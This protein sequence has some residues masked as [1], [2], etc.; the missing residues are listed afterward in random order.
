MRSQYFRFEPRW[1]DTARQIAA[2]KVRPDA[3]PGRKAWE[4]GPN[5]SGLSPDG[6]TPLGKL[7]HRRCDPMLAQAGGLGM[8]SQYFRFEPR[9]GDTARQ[10]AAPKVRLDA[11]PGRKAW[12]C[13][14]NISG[15]NPDGATPL[16]KLQHRRCDSMLAQAGRPG[17]AV[18][19][20]QV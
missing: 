20:F 14:P 8:R 11:S 10:I 19:I 16:G 4:C 2:P 12:E 3:S 18:P 9:W 7:Q 13:G 1:G 6:A 5:I 15:L 17:N